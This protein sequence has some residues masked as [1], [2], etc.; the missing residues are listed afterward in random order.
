MSSAFALLQTFLRRLIAQTVEAFRVVEVEIV[1]ADPWL[2]SEEILDPAQLRHRVLDQLVTVHYENLLPGEHLQ[3]PMHVR[4]V[5]GNRYWPVRL[6]DA[7]VRSYHQF[8]EATRRLLLLDTSWCSIRQ[9]RSGRGV[10][11]QL[12]VV[13][14]RSGHWFP[15]YQQQLHARVHRADSFRYLR[16]EIGDVRNYR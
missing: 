4:V 14:Y 6:V 9:G 5:Q 13:G 8:L 7:A 1:P 10:R 11:P 2:Q 12:S 16:R 15:H 3:P